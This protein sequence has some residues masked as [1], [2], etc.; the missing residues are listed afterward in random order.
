VH[1]A[2]GAGSGTRPAP[3]PPSSVIDTG[4]W[5]MS[6]TSRKG[7]C[8]RRS[9]G[10]PPQS[11][12]QY[13]LATSVGK[14]RGGR[15]LECR[16]GRRRSWFPLSAATLRATLRAA[17]LAAARGSWTP[18]S[19]PST[20]QT[21]QAQ[22]GGVAPVPPR[23]Q[24]PRWQPCAVI[25]MAALR[26]SRERHCG[27]RP[28]SALCSFRGRPGT[29]VTVVDDAADLRRRRSRCGR[30]VAVFSTDFSPHSLG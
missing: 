19:Q 16:S 8:S 22:A 30:G 13:P 4:R 9:A 1:C 27:T 29:L 2:G 3:F 7:H 18:L 15:D 26:G 12:G 11:I 20:W 23:R 5:P 6:R 25:V 21:Q 14:I 24:P 17:P 28:V 10:Q